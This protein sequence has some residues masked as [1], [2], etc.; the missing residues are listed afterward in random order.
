MIAA[1]TAEAWAYV[2][3]LI[4]LLLILVVDWLTW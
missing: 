4:V 3:N 2:G 1:M